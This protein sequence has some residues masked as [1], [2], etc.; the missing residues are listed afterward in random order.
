MVLIF[1]VMLSN[2]M[3]IKAETPPASLT[4]SPE[5]NFT[6]A[7]VNYDSTL[8]NLNG[9]KS[10]L[11]TFESNYLP[12]TI[13]YEL[14]Q[15]N[16]TYENQLNAY[17]DSVS[18][19]DWTS[20]LNATA[21]E[22]QKANFGR[23]S[24]FSTQ[25]GTAI[26]ALSVEQYLKAN[27]VSSSLPNDN[28]YWIYVFNL[29][30]F[31][32]PTQDHW[33]NI[34]EVDP[35]AQRARFFWR[36]EWDYDLGNNYNVKFP[37]AAFS[38]N[39]DVMFMDLT[40]FQWYLKWRVIWNDISNPDP[41]YLNDLDSRLQGLTQTEK[42]SV[43]ESTAVTWL[44]DWIALIYNMRIDAEA[45]GSSMSIQLNVMYRSSEISLSNIDWIINTKQTQANVN[46]LFQ[47]DNFNVTAHFIDMDQDKVMSG[48]FDSYK[49]SYYNITGMNYTPPFANW[50][51]YD[52]NGLY[53]AISGSQASYF[54]LS[55]ANIVLRG[56]IYLVD[57]SSFAANNTPWVGGLLTGLGG[58]YRLTI[59][60]EL[61]RALMSDHVTRKSGLS[62]VLVHEIGHA[63]G[64]PHTF[65]SAPPRFT[66]DF[67]ADT[68]GYYPSSGN[69]YEILSL[70]YQRT[71]ADKLF[72]YV[73][74]LYQSVVSTNSEQSLL[75]A[76]SHFDQ[77]IVFHKT[78]QFPKASLEL[79][80]AVDI[81]RNPN[82]S[83]SKATNQSSATTGNGERRVRF[84][85]P[86]EFFIIS[87]A[88]LTVGKK[89]KQKRYL[90]Y[91]ID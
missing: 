58:N 13:N 34:T 1:I 74:S 48:I 47:S 53:Y 43:I 25:N 16:T 26:D 80:Q 31:D 21:L 70:Q 78:K 76:K 45:L 8:L 82:Q 3:G 44:K 62:R 51:Y 72:Q 66:S 20:S 42:Q 10:Q 60:Y 33:F 57:N 89:L 17:I 14:V 81:L 28:H 56:T 52:A 55:A 12:Y 35:D 37:Y 38:K 67:L 86:I 79:Q 39:T 84:P 71:A 32:S 63:I 85:F 50:K 46:N 40:A 24:I 90:Q 6:I 91:R 4:Y 41:S 19:S 88:V 68:M 61:D 83:S 11:P 59:L 2:Q 23:K 77:A 75:D 64:I 73:T 30:R 69:Y 5:Q 36:L 7:F 87:F 9:I 18:Q 15:T 49:D 27:P 54:N 22:E 29:S 65:S